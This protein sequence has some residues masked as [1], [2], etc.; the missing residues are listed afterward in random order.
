MDQNALSGI[1][2]LKMRSSVS[3]AELEA[4]DASYGNN[5]QAHAILCDMGL[6]TPPMARSIADGIQTTEAGHDGVEWG[7][8]ALR[9][10]IDTLRDKALS[11]VSF[12]GDSSGIGIGVRCATVSDVA[13]ALSPK[14]QSFLAKHGA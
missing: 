9:D 7:Y 2:A 6:A 5:Y 13:K 12:K 10:G 14:I 4:A 1:Q 8:E 3:Q 11:A